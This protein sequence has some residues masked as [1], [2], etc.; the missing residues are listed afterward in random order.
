VRTADVRVPALLLA[1]ILLAAGCGT[2]T[3]ERDF[4]LDAATIAS[5]AA[6]GALL[7][8]EVGEQNTTR[9]FAR[10]HGGELGDTAAELAATLRRSRPVDPVPA[11]RLAA[12]ADAVSRRLH[13]VASLPPP[14]RAFRLE[15]Q[16]QRLSRRASD[17]EEQA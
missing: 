17:L 13:L 7:A 8:H 9:A 10:V 1:V 5:I 2:T 12:V 16:L 4:R 6:E 11:R 3:T 15:R 14:Q